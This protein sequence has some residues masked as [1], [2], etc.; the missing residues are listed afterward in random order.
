MPIY[1]Y[2]GLP[3]SGKTHE[4]ASQVE[5]L[6]SRN[7]KWSKKSGILRPVYSNLPFNEDWNNKW[8]E[9]LKYWRDPMQLPAL[10]DCD[11]FWD[12]IPV[13]LDSRGWENLSLSLRAWLQQHRH[14]GIEIYFT[15]QDFFQIDKSFRRLVDSVERCYKLIGS[16]NPSAT[17]PPVKRIWGVIVRRTL[18]RKTMLKDD[19][20]PKYDLWPG[21]SFI[22]RKYA[23]AYDISYTIEQGVYPPLQHVDRTCEHFPKCDFKKTIHR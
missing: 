17:K 18:E 8:G 21:I 4:G 6:L 12:E 1:G 14:F 23:T 15:A 22:H 7:R 19:G 9:G 16:R 2:E 5:T 11:I 3:G 10:R 13:H 20:D